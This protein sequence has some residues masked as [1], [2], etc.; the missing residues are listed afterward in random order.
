MNKYPVYRQNII[1]YITSP[2]STV[3]IQIIKNFFTDNVIQRQLGKTPAFLLLLDTKQIC[4]VAKDFQCELQQNK[5]N[6]F[7][8]TT[9]PDG[10]GNWVISGK[11]QNVVKN[12][13]NNIK[14]T[15]TFYDALGNSI[16]TYKQGS[17]TPAKLVSQQY[18]VFHLN[19]LKPTQ[20]WNPVFLRL[21]Y[22]DPTSTLS[23]VTTKTIKNFFTDNVIQR[24]LGKT[25]AFLLLLDTRQFC[26]VA[27]DFQCELQQNK[28][29]TFDLTTT[30]DG[31]GNW[32][33]SGK[34]QNVVKNAI[35]NIKVTATFYD[36]L[37]NNIGT[38]KQGSVTPAKLV[39]QQ[40]GV[41]NMKALKSTQ[42]WNPVFLRLEYQ[43]S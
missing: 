37:G 34:V 27:K 1:N 29:N 30:P 18:G 26:H 4:H 25:P 13:I 3:N 21:E 6:T 8:L 38:Y 24:Q 36:A 9:T 43:G 15:A 16:G 19:V 41:F 17:V 23:T 22:Q 12:A 2:T 33:I 40:Y 14:V 5:F 11:V 42:N 35:N 31:K 20:N 7:D 28:F 10:K 32:V 39:S